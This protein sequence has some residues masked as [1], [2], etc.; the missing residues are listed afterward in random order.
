LRS[1][2]RRLA[3]EDEKREKRERGRREKRENPAQCGLITHIYSWLD[4]PAIRIPITEIDDT[5]SDI[6]NSL[7]K[8]E[9]RE[10]KRG[11]GRLEEK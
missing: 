2:N 5:V 11:K 8:R 10:E 1:T 4:H 7:G 6:Y 9:R 3:V